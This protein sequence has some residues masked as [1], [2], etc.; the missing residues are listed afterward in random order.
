MNE[1]EQRKLSELDNIKQDTARKIKRKNIDV[2]IIFEIIDLC[3][4]EMQNL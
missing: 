3:V 2:E 4:E 1:E